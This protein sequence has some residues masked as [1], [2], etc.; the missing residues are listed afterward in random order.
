VTAGSSLFLLRAHEQARMIS[1]KERPE[2]LTVL[3]TVV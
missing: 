3:K 1:D 2:I